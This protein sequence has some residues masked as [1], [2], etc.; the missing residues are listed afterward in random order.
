MYYK[1]NT[2]KEMNDE[3]ILHAFVHPWIWY[4]NDKFHILDV[5]KINAKIK[6]WNKKQQHMYIYVLD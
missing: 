2:L 6:K 1:N 5:T 3:Y 4:M